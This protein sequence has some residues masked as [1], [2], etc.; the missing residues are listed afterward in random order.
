MST[1][2]GATNSPVQSIASSASRVLAGFV[3]ARDD[4]PDDADVGPAELAAADV[5][6]R[7][8]REQ[9]VERLPAL[10]G[11]HRPRPQ[12]RFDGIDAHDVLLVARHPG[13]W[14]SG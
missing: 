6:H 4:R 8:A 5:D 13:A 1:K 3:D 12:R 11:R 9:Q 14:G 10:R 7:A 2:P